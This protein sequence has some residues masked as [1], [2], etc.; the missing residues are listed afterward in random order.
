MKGRRRRTAEDGAALVSDFRA[1]GLTQAKYAAQAGITLC[2][3]QY[4]IKRQH[5]EKP[6]KSKGI[7]RFVEIRPRLERNELGHR[8]V[9]VTVGIG[10][11]VTLSFT[12]LPQP[13]Y[14]AELT[15]AMM[16]LVPC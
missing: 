14:L 16:S 13:E 2:S 4:W 11:M 6:A 3:L 15:R 5:Q 9:A 1:S 10:Q 7:A 12:A 8:P